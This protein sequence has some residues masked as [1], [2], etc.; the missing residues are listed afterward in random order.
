MKHFVAGIFDPNFSVPEV[1]SEKKLGPIKKIRML[2]L[3]ENDS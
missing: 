2:I 3:A 1:A